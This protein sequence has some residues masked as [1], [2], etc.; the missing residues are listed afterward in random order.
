MDRKDYTDVFAWAAQLEEQQAIEDDD[1]PIDDM[2]LG[3]NNLQSTLADDQ[4][5][6][7]AHP[8]V[9]WVDEYDMQRKGRAYVATCHR[10]RQTFGST[11][12]ESARGRVQRHILRHDLPPIPTYQLPDDCPF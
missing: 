1:F 12:D 3:W 6:R 2:D 4:L 5:T 9:A 11:H 10:C 7:Y 8:D